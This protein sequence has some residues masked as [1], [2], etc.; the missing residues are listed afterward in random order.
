MKSITEMRN[1]LLEKAEVSE[2]F[3]ARLILTRR[4]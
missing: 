3:R 2:E 1:H 4:P